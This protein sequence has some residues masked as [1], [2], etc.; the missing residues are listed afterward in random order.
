MERFGLSQIQATAILD[1]RLA[2]LTA[3]ESESIKREHEDVSER[4]RE[5]RELLG[6]EAQRPGADQGGA[7]RDRRALRRRPPHRDHRQ[8]G[9]PQHRGPDP[10]PA[11]GHHDHAHRLHQVAAARDLPPAA[12]RRA[13][14]DRDGHEGRRLHR[15]PL[16]VLVARLPAVLLQ[17]RQGLPLQGLRAA[18]GVAHR[19]GPRARQR[20]AA[21]R[22]RAH[23]GRAR[24]A[25]LHGDEVP[26]LRDPQRHREEDR[27]PGLQHADQGRRDHRDQHPRRRRAA[28]RARGRS[29][30]RDHHGLAQ[31]ARRALRRVRRALD[32]PRHD[33]ACAAWTSATRAR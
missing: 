15:A 7:Q 32:G 19:E 14:R 11:D 8:R 26:R 28:R 9:R 23:P 31:G 27:V 4:I 16:R 6:S 29:R 20:A 22:G 5:L 33:A 2:Q 18:G 17:P 21:A 13:R 10:R 1:L 3:L 12:A 25:R 24:D 30:G